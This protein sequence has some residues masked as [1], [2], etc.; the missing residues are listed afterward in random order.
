MSNEENSYWNGWD[1]VVDQIIGK[2]DESVTIADLGSG[3]GEVGQLLHEAGYRNVDAYD[4][5]VIQLEERKLFYRKTYWSNIVKKVLYGKYDIIAA[6]GFFQWGQTKDKNFLDGS[7]DFKPNSSDWDNLMRNIH[8]SLKDDGVMIV[9]VP[10]GR[11]LDETKL[12]NSPFWKDITPEGLENFLG[13]KENWKNW[14]GEDVYQE[15]YFTTKIMK[16]K[17]HVE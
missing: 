4:I 17:T 16:K 6:S 11:Y 8:N 3:K 9:T 12:L 5:D 7:A 1:H 13:R 10:C 2:Y 14:Q 15:F